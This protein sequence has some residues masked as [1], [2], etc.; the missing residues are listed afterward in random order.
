MKPWKSHVR[1]SVRTGGRPEEERRMVGARTALTI[2]KR[3]TSSDAASIAAVSAITKFAPRA[4][5]KPTRV[6]HMSS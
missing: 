1:G 6:L 3:T 5:S 2:L 4:L